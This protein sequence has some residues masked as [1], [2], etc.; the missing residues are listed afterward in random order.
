M[1]EENKMAYILQFR[2]TNKYKVFVSSLVDKHVA[3]T[4]PDL[5]II[6]FGIF[7]SPSV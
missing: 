6:I 7:L 1:L 4:S 3:H 5:T 2:Q